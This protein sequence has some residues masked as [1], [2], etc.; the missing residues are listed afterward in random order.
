MATLIYILS[1]FVAGCIAT[2]IIEAALGY[3]VLVLVSMIKN[4]KK[5]SP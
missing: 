1:G 3:V 2:L 4:G 5:V